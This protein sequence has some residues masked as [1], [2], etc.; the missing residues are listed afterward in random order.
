MIGEYIS[1]TARKVTTTLLGK[2]KQTSETFKRALKETLEYRHQ[3]HSE[4]TL[5][6]LWKTHQRHSEEALNE[7]RKTQVHP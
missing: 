4:E 1:R 5:N 6:V 7:L 3:R 2:G